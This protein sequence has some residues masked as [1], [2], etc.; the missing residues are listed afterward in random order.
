[1]STPD[2]QNI[3]SQSTRRGSPTKSRRSRSGTRMSQPGGTTYAKTSHGIHVPSYHAT[4]GGGYEYSTPPPSTPNRQS[5]RRRSGSRRR[6]SSSRSRSRSPRSRAGTSASGRYNYPSQ[7][8][9]HQ[10]TGINT[11][12]PPSG[13]PVRQSSPKKKRPTS[14]VSKPTSWKQNTDS[15]KIRGMNTEYIRVPEGGHL[16]LPPDTIAEIVNASYRVE[17]NTKHGV[18]KDVTGVVKKHLN[19]GGI[20]L[21]VENSHLGIGNDPYPGVAKVLV[22]MYVP[23]V[24]RGLT[25]MII[26][27]GAMFQLPEGAIDTLLSAE[28]KLNYDEVSGQG[29]ASDVTGAL[30]GRVKRGGIPAFQVSR[31]TL[32][33]PYDPFP[34][35]QKVLKI[36]YLRQ[37]RR[38]VDFSDVTSQT[39]WGVREVD[40]T[41]GPNPPY[42]PRE[43]HYYRGGRDHIPGVV[44]S[45]G[46]DSHHVAILEAVMALLEDVETY[47]IANESRL[48]TVDHLL[49]SVK[50]DR[51]NRLACAAGR[52]VQEH[53]TAGFWSDPVKVLSRMGFPE[54]EA[55]EAMH[56]TN[57]LPD[58]AR[59]L[60]QKP[61]YAATTRGY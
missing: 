20:D 17:D 52:I 46:I 36:Q 3:S 38:G 40:G 58:A 7:Y 18:H 11:P 29:W 24:D 30:W 12:P 22:I 59:L 21:H 43:D 42:D 1:M 19:Q 10:L 6:R 44:A 9:V 32:L 54:H 25:E 57:S 5:S 4:G 39:A 50:L 31:E 23:R 8:N 28:Y 47:G 56:R 13:R 49:E 34:G 53:P 26:P 27:E 35:R 16:Q 51:E 48:R 33:I 2:W 45:Q 14:V 15:V 55:R 37:R 60:S 61:R 41:I